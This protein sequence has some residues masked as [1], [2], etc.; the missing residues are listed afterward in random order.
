[1]NDKAETNDS[2]EKSDEIAASVERLVITDPCYADN[3]AAKWRWKMDYCKSNGIPAGQSWAWDRAE[4]AY[5]VN[6]LI[7]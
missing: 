7:S 5:N 6:S 2:A 3:V 4:D 1:M